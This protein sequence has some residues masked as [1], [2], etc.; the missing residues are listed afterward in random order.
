MEDF[1]GGVTESFDLSKDMEGLFE[2]MQRNARRANLMSCSIKVCTVCVRMYRYCIAGI[3]REV[4]F[5]WF[6]WLRGEPRSFYPR[7]STT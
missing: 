4:K 2:K 6:S 1:T 7:N 3:F 5:L